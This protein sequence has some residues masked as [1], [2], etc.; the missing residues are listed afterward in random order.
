MN[1]V[2]ILFGQFIHT[3]ENRNTKKN[4]LELARSFYKEIKQHGD[5]VRHPV[6]LKELLRS[7]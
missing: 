4:D 3:L 7:S 5:E 2:Q 1:D 6:D